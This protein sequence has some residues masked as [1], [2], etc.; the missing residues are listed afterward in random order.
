MTNLG[1]DA[2][3][4]RTRPQT[5]CWEHEEPTRTI[6][7]QL[8]S[9]QSLET[10]AFLKP[11]FR[12]MKHGIRKN[13][14]KDTEMVDKAFA[15]AEWMVQL[16]TIGDAEREI[17]VL[18]KLQPSYA[19]NTIV[20]ASQRVGSMP[21]ALR[22]FDLLNKHGYEP[23]VFTHTALIDVI[24]RN[25]DVPAAIK[26]YEAMRETKSRPNIVTYTTLIRSIAST[27]EVDSIECVRFLA[28]AREE[29]TFD[30]ALY[31][32]ALEVCAMR[33]NLPA[34]TAVLHDLK[35]NGRDILRNSERLVHAIAQVIQG[36]E[37]DEREEI[38][39]EWTAGNLIT[40]E[41]HD[42]ITSP[43]TLTANRGVK[44]LG[45]LSYQTSHSV[46]QAVV[47]HDITRLVERVH[48]GATVSTNDFETLLHQCRKR[49]WKDEIVV[50]VDSMRELA[51]K[52][53]Q[54]VV[55][56]GTTVHVPPQPHLRPASKTYVSIVDAYLCC[57]DEPLAWQ[58]FQEVAQYSELS[59]E[60]PLYRKFIRGKYLLTNCD[61][62]FE[63]LELANQDKMIFSHRTCVQLAR[64]HGHRHLEGLEIILTKLPGGV[65][66]EKKQ[67]LLEE[68]ATSCGYKHNTKGVEDTLQGMLKHGF[69][70]SSA[71]EIAVFICCLQHQQLD[72]AVKMLRYF[73][74]LNLMMRI[75]MYDSLLRE[76]YFKYTRRG[77]FFDDSSRNV[78]LR[79]LNSRRVMF[80]KVF[81]E[82]DALESWNESCD[83]DYDVP[84]KDLS[85]R[86]SHE[87]A[88]RYWCERAELKCAPLMFAQHVIEVIATIR[89]KEA[90]QNAQAM[91]REALLTTKD[92]VLFN[93]RAVVSLRFLDLT[94]RALGKFSKQMLQLLTDANGKP[95]EVQKHHA[96]YCICQLPELTVHIVKELDDFVSLHAS[97]RSEILSFCNDAL[98]NDNMDKTIG[99]IVHQK[100]LY[101]M[102][103]VEYLVPKLAEMYVLNGMVTVLQFFRPEVEDS[104]AMRRLFLREV[105]E[106]EMVADEEDENQ[107]ERF[108][109][110]IRAILEF[111]LEHEDEF[112][113]FLLHVVPT[114]TA[115][116]SYPLAVDDPS[117]EYLKLP[118]ASDCV[119]FVDN[120]DMV[121]LA[122]EILMHDCIR[123]LGIDA[124]WRPDLGS[125][126]MQSKC[127]IL[128]VA[129]ESHVFIF[130]LL[131]L[132]ISDLEDLFT[133]LFTSRSIVKLGFGLDGDIKRLRW[134]F[135]D[136]RCFETF[137]NV[138]DF[139]LDESASAKQ[140]IAHDAE[141]K[142]QSESHVDGDESFELA[143]LKH[144]RRRQRGLAAYVYEVLGLPLSKAQQKS[145][146]ERRPLTEEQISYAALDAYCLVMVYQK[147]LSASN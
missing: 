147:A 56:D 96:E 61:H 136:T 130:D 25:G 77:G 85:P 78:A 117:K 7:H 88:L 116:N 63:M 107:H 53:W 115:S 129:C 131:E 15:F 145:D 138:V 75:P 24:A 60:L 16:Q 118:L 105:I 70:R 21:D 108:S 31:L 73:Q 41:E 99:F 142:K 76:M 27:D 48:N 86:E 140:A 97:H 119:I 6:V 90:K 133:H 94:Y 14:D 26:R 44:A 32:E 45:C 3:Q 89:D 122:Y 46:R 29:E 93:L 80:S 2:Q 40:S 67:V 146:W 20:T 139:S 50:I 13:G 126:H 132:A 104:L 59:R 47:Q 135:P 49:K 106:V 8:Q 143:N 52:G 134:S 22:A 82:L 137:I 87:F 74:S 1:K 19:L 109:C 95:L 103:T 66:E 102:E 81:S 39:A 98:E 9:G 127:S 5:W 34:A 128:Q 144:R 123:M 30:E 42:Q 71:T 79:T 83:Y 10:R 110:T 43:D 125:G 141:Q 36:H 11:I 120:D 65:T 54:L 58:S 17:P 124:E 68:L 33:K 62:I 37:D 91:I 18:E 111:K 100:E 64:M 38:L 101:T 4:R 35:C 121:A 12:W 28:H 57:E 72:G 69:H 114:P 55:N 112:M 92:P 51:D 23:D 84:A 113:P